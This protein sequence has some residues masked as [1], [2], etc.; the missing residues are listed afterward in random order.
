M[1]ANFRV[2]LTVALR[3][4]EHASLTTWLQGER[5]KAKIKE[6]GKRLP[7]NPDGFFTI[8]HKGRRLH[9]FLE[10]DRST[11]TRAVYQGKLAR[12]W[13]WWKASGYQR[14]DGLNIP[15]F[16]LLTLTLTEKRKET[17]RDL[18]R[19][20]DQRQQGSAMFLFASERNRNGAKTFPLEEP[21]GIL[22]PIWQC[23]EWKAGTACSRWHSLLE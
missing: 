22:T 6:K 16:R 5:L 4:L 1:I 2:A 13:Q 23:G 10:A 15:R 3:S 8:E 20:A 21:G 12:Y 7:I 11:E 14:K 19:Y 17:L 18:A 9:F